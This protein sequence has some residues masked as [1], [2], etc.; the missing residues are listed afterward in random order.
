ML[1]A[2]IIEPTRLYRQILSDQFDVTGIAKVFVES[3]EEALAIVEE[4]NFDLILSALDLPGMNGFEFCKALRAN[5]QTRHLPLVMITVDDDK[6]NL[7]QAHLAGVTEL[8]YKS[9]IDAIARYLSNFIKLSANEKLLSGRILFIEDS[10]S[11][12]LKIS[13]L[14]NQSGYEVVHFT[15]AEDAL[16]YFATD[17]FDLVITDILLEGKMQGTE[18]IRCIRNLGD[19]R[20]N[21]PIMVITGYDDASRKI[22]LLRSGAN[23]Y[24]SKPVIKEE[25]LARVSNLVKSKQQLDRIEIQQQKLHDLAMKDQLTG[26]YNRHYLA[27]VAVKMMAEA[28]RFGSPLSLMVVD[29]D[30]FK[31]LN[32]NYGHLMGDQVLIAVASELKSKRRESD[33]AARFGGE[34]F[35][36]LLSHC[37]LEQAAIIAENLRQ[38]VHDLTP[39]QLLVSASF[40]VTTLKLD[41]PSVTF[42]LLFQQADKALYQAKEQGRNKV[43]CYVDEPKDAG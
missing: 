15:N 34:E 25:L 17:N 40:G 26:L 14:L 31:K 41:D 3:G 27:D 2:L 5:D 10:K 11:V 29:I 23:D 30:H 24:I 35:V 7:E 36:I 1:R 37:T 12:A 9:N 13:S 20:S 6:A 16:D 33:V 22:G 28:R 18:M 39:C 42:D 4:G 8:L 21:T 38:T 43:V 32:D 19:N